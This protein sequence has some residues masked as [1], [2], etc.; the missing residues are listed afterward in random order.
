MVVMTLLVIT[1]FFIVPRL[2]N[3][4]FTNSINRTARW[5]DI[6]SASLRARSQA[7]QRRCFLRVDM[8]ARVLTAMAASNQDDGTVDKDE[9]VDSPFRDKDAATEKAP[10]VLGK[11]VLP[12]DTKVVD[13]AFP[14]MQ[15][16]Y[17]GVVDIYFYKE[18]YADRAVIHMRNG[19][20]MVSFFV[21]PFL[22]RVRMEDG[23]AD[24]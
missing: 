15:V 3:T 16:F 12:S 9:P 22:A 23:Y 13:V 19:D 14:D 21:E 6:A 2:S 1:L 7:E 10:V 20:R 18:G 4:S 11:F 17:D 24:F 5:L 8:K